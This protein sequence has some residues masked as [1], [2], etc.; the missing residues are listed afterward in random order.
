MNDTDGAGDLNNG[1]VTANFTFSSAGE[2]TRSNSSCVVIDGEGTTYSQNYSCTIGLY[3]FDSQGDWNVTVYGEDVS[4]ASAINNSEYFQYNQLQA[5]KISP[6]SI[7]FASISPGATNESS[8][9][10]PT[11][12]N[13]TGNYNVTENNIQINATNL[14]GVDDAS[15]LINVSNFSIHTVT[16]SGNESCIGGINPTNATSVSITGAFLA[17]GNNSLSYGNSTSGQE[18]IL[19]YNS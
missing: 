16:G 15:F 10:H 5:I 19:Y 2:A 18:Q 8:N 3:Y 1:S 13:N 7:T 4:A 12:I 17:K 14:I 6:T 9:N 11:L